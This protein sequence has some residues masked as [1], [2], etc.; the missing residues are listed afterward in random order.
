MSYYQK[1]DSSKRKSLEE[2]LS[3]NGLSCTT[4][5]TE[6]PIPIYLSYLTC[7]AADLPNHDL[8]TDMSLKTTILYDSGC[9]PFFILR[10]FVKFMLHLKMECKNR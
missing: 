4:Q 8:S 2:L 6:I 10:V 5:L 7:L 1:Y 3:M 9:I